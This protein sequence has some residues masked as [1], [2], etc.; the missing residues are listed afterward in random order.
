MLFATLKQRDQFLTDNMGLVYSRVLKNNRGEYDEDLLQE[1]FL[2]LVK[3][4]DRFDSSRNCQFSTYAVY[5]IDGYIK[6]YKLRNQ[7]IKPCDM[8]GQDGKR[9]YRFRE[10]VS[11]DKTYVGAS[12]NLGDIIPDNSNIVEDAEAQDLAERFEAK[13]KGVNS[14]IVQMLIAGYKQAEIA[15]YL[16]LSRQCVSQRLGK[17]AE[18]WRVCAAR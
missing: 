16:N 14:T 6:R 15:A 3:A 5:Y 1:G 17:I 2:A 8:K 4:A 13:L 9:G 7:T 10:C 18:Q 11:L 12:T